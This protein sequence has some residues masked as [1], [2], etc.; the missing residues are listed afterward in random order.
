MVVERLPGEDG[1]VLHQAGAVLRCQVGAHPQLREAL[2][3]G[4][5]IGALHG[6]TASRWWTTVAGPARS[7]RCGPRTGPPTLACPD[8]CHL[9]RAG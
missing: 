7:P 1:D 5:G 2:G 3:D 8:G 4:S 6:G 9:A